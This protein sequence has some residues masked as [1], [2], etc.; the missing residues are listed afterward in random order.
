MFKFKNGDG[1]KRIFF[2]DRDTFETNRGAGTLTNF[3]GPFMR[4]TL[5]ASFVRDVCPLMSR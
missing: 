3:I 2:N 5:L 4:L 1:A